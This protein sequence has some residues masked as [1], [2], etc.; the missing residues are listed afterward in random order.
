[1]AG[2]ANQQNVEPASI[3]GEEMDQVI[4]RLKQEV[5][6]YQQAQSAWQNDPQHD[7]AKLGVVSQCS[8]KGSVDFKLTKVKLDLTTTTSIKENGALSLKIPFAGGTGTVGP[9]ISGSTET[10]NTN[11]LVLYAYPEA[12]TFQN[13]E[14]SDVVRK[15]SAIA[16]TLIALR[17]SLIR[18]STSKP[19]FDLTQAGAKDND[20][21]SLKFAV[22]KDVNPSL[23]FNFVILSASGGYD[24]NSNVG[25]TITVTFTPTG[26]AFFA[27]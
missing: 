6:M 25:N 15:N 3:A 8:A 1:V 2:C 19:C 4:L 12:S 24:H 27:D 7:P 26:S 22:K 16:G 5:A 11:E 21:F 13:V 17:E 20:T 9:G 18:S 10:D 14:I 23:G